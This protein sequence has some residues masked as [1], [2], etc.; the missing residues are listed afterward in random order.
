MIGG[1]ILANPGTAQAASPCPG[2][3]IDSMTVPNGYGVVE[4]FYSNG[5]N[6]VVTRQTF[7]DTNVQRSMEASIKLSTSNTWK[8]DEGLY[9]SYA[10]PVSVYAPSKCIDWGGGV[11]GYYTWELNSH[12][13]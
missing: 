1:L 6:C 5:Y 13:G 9:Y 12:C 4:L 2:T 8:T 10:G 11:L 3:K 7:G